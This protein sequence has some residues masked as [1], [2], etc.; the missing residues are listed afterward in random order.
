MP[1]DHDPKALEEVNT[2]VEK[3]YAAWKKYAAWPQ[4]RMD[5]VVEKMAEAGRAQA[6]RLAEMAVEETGYGNVED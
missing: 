6:R 4:E 1:H 5:V 3:A 2:K